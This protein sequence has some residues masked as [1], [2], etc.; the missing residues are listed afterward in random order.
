VEGQGIFA[1]LNR[2]WQMPDGS[3]DKGQMVDVTPGRYELEEIS[4]P[5][6]YDA[7]WLVLKGTMIGMT[8]RAWFDWVGLPEEDE[9]NIVIEGL[10]P[11]PDQDQEESCR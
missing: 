10:E 11:D 3:Q 5:Y 8:K 7:N 9:F 1:T 2:T 4:N 6:G